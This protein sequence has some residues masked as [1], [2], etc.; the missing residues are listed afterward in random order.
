MVLCSL[1]LLLFL[2]PSAAPGRLLCAGIALANGEGV[3][4]R[5]DMVKLES[6]ESRHSPQKVRFKWNWP[7]KNRSSKASPPSAQNVALSERALA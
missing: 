7:C 6:P 3:G 2:N 5:G 4:K 1:V